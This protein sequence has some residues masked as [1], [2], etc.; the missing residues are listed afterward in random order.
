MK[1]LVKKAGVAIIWCVLVLLHAPV[2]AQ[3]QDYVRSQTP[4]GTFTSDDKKFSIKIS[5]GA[6]IPLGDFGS[7]NV[8]GSFWDFNSIDSTRLQGFATTGFHF[9]ISLAY[10]IHDFFGISLMIGDNING[11]DLNAFSLAVGFPATVSS[12]STNYSTAEFLIGPVFNFNLASKLKLT[13]GIYIGL[14]RNNYPEFTIS[15]NDTL[16]D[17]RT[18]QN[19]NLSFAYSV[20]GG[21]SYAVTDNIDITADVSYTGVA[22]HYPSWTDTYQAISTNPAY[23]YLPL[24]F[25][26]PNNKTTMATGI[27]KPCI[28]VVFKF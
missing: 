14:A 18:L 15:L 8:K 16:T 6:A 11:I 19:G 25:N 5:A 23:Y 26:H 3:D 13:A 12:S 22:L 20:S 17:T 2:K 24:S 9:D 21:I 28:G 4:G 10:Y 7:T 1:N 27:L